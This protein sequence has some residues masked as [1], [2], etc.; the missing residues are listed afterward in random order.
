MKKVLDTD[1]KDDAVAFL[2]SKFRRS[3]FFD[4]AY[5][6]SYKLKGIKLASYLFRLF[7]H[8][9]KFWQMADGKPPDC[10]RGCSYCCYMQVEVSQYEAMY[11]AKHI[12]KNFTKPEIQEIKQKAK[13]GAEEIKDADADWY[14]GKFR[15]C[16]LLDTKTGD[17]T[18]YDA[19]P[20][21]CR[22]VYSYDVQKCVTGYQGLT[23]DN[24]W[25]GG[26][27]VAAEDIQAGQSVADIERDKFEN[28]SIDS[29]LAKY[30]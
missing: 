2:K 10:K 11:L 3:Q 25:W 14:P 1:R 5:Q 13:I 22:R 19:R 27:F 20:L 18:A 26:P 28:H 29:A 17:C 6:A 8:S 4:Y 21:A 24:K 15:P 16:I 23:N 9:K 30:L 7:D 12:K